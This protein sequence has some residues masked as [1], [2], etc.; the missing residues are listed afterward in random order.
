M[1]WV[2]TIGS[3]LGPN[4]GAPGQLVS[5]ITGLTVF[6]AA[7]LIAAIFLALGGLVTLVWLRPDPLLVLAASS[8]AGIVPARRSSP[9]TDAVTA[10]ATKGTASSPGESAAESAATTSRKPGRVRLMLAEL[11]VNRRARLAVGA[12]LSAQI[13]MVAVMTMTP[14]H[15]THHGGSVAIVGITIS[16]HIAAMFALAPLVGAL[17]DRYGH[18]LAILVGIAIFAASLVTGAIAGEGTPGIVTSLILLGIGWSFVNVAGSAL[19]SSAVPDRVRASSQ[20]GVD[21]LSNLCGAIAALASG[22]LLMATDFAVLSIVALLAL[23]PL[24]VFVG[25]RAIP[26]AESTAAHDEMPAS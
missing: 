11:R 17:V 4:L 13:V 26:P 6:A 12:I 22:P 1:V 10:D 9:A 8:P 21:A 16:L 25:L 15:I 23:V 2:G 19:F 18:R 20:G 24:L 7:F 3:A 14:V 5:E